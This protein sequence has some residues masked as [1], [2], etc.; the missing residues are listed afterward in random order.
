MNL[1][2]GGQVCLGSYHSK[3]EI[4]ALYLLHAVLKNGY[5]RD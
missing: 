4:S 5:F 2:L 3:L 1:K